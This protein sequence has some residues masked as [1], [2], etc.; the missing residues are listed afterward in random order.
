MRAALHRPDRLRRCLRQWCK[1]D[2]ITTS[3]APADIDPADIDPSD[4]ALIRD[5]AARLGLI[6]AEPGRGT[7]RRL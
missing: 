7:S 5:A 6:S 1:G 2:R 3:T 4:I